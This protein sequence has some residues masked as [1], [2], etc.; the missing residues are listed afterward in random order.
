MGICVVEGSL[1]SLPSE[2]TN[3]DFGTAAGDELASRRAAKAAG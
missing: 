1:A 3:D 2:R